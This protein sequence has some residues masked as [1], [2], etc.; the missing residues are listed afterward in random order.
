[1][2]QRRVFRDGICS[3]MQMNSTQAQGSRKLSQFFLQPVES[4][5][6]LG[7]ERL[8]QSLQP[9]QRSEAVSVKVKSMVTPLGNDGTAR[10]ELTPNR[11][12]APW[13]QRAVAHLP[14]AYRPLPRHPAV[15]G[16]TLQQKVTGQGHTPIGSEH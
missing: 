16:Q 6:L 7:A 12:R 5:R 13:T 8:L 10:D 1:M 15:P 9:E 3:D 11:Q 4:A 14:S 2:E